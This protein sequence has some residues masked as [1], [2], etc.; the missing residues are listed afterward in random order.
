MP[1]QKLEAQGTHRQSV[2]E[3]F[4]RRESQVM[5]S[6]KYTALPPFCYCMGILLHVKDTVPKTKWS[7]CKNKIQ[8]LEKYYNS[9]EMQ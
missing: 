7:T 3:Q 4:L 8:I 9:K 5:A 6:W 2:L 1:T